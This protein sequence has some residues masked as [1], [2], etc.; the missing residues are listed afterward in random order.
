M[1]QRKSQ[2]PTEVPTPPTGFD[3][4][5]PPTFLAELIRDLG[6]T[7][8]DDLRMTDQERTQRWQ[9]SFE[10]LLALV[11]TQMSEAILACQL[12][13]AHCVTMDTFRRSM[14]TF[15]D[16][17]ARARLRVAGSQLMRTCLATL[18]EQDRA[19]TRATGPREK[20]D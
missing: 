15:M 19:R 10:G 13:A 16:E 6:S 18:R 1:S 9:A 3:V 4:P 17:S 7:Q 12:L 2:F 8:V 20:Q 14:V 11:P 5:L